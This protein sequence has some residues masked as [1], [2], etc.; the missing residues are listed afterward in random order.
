MRFLLCHNYYQQRGGEDQVFED[1]AWLLEHHGH[2]VIRYAVHNDSIEGMGRSQ[3]V[4]ATFWNKQAA[5]EV[6][7]LIRQFR[8]DVMH[9]TNTFPLISPS[10]LHVATAEGVAVVQTLQN[11][12][13]F[14]PSSN[15]LRTGKICELCVNR[16]FAWP[17]VVHGCYRNDRMATAVVA[18]MLMYHQKIKSW[19]T[20]VDRFIVPSQITLQK[21]VEAGFPSD[22]ISIKPNFLHPDPEP[23]NG[24]GGFAVFAGRL[25]PE[26][27]IQTMLDSWKLIPDPIPLV[28]VGDGPMAGVVRD[29]AASDSRISWLG[30][31]PL[32]E[33][34]EI[35]GRSRCLLMP[36]IWY[37]PFGRTVIEA[38]AVGTPVI[39]S[40]L[41]A[42]L[43]LVN[44]GH[45]G[46]FFQPG[47]AAD[48][49]RS[50]LKMFHPDA[51]WDKMRSAARQEYLDKYTAKTNYIE[52]LAIYDSV[53]N[54][55]SVKQHT[56]NPMA[57]KPV[58]LQASQT[59]CE[60]STTTRAF[61]DGRST[62][63]L[64]WPEKFDLLGVHVSA[65][66]YQELTD[67]I[68]DAAR[69]HQ[70]AVVSCHAAH[71]IVTASRSAE[72][73]QQV[74]TFEAVTPDGQPVRW[75]LNRLFGTRLKDRVYGPE[76]MLRVCAAAAQQQVSIYLYGGTP[77]V[78]SKLSSNLLQKFPNL[79]ISGSEAPPFR[80]LTADED[81][82]MIQRITNSRAGIVF[83]GLGCPKQ[84][85]FAYAHRRQISAVQICVGAAFD[86]HAGVKS[87]APQ[88]MQRIGLEW[89]FRLG[90][91]PRRL[92]K[93]Y[94]ITNSLF[95]RDFLLQW[96]FQ[97]T[98]RTAGK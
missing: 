27:G 8:P 20:M 42:M 59:D 63:R 15:L 6:R 68:L 65:T 67:R 60:Q 13:L 16:R 61:G 10:I 32:T 93:R 24:E 41:G 66:H 3:L 26:K 33:V 29:A 88:W 55:R 17:A 79:R 49:S 25:S 53:L 28:I 62:E 4:R 75:A 21:Y 64:A 69:D 52:L 40:R 74:N 48:L 76:L 30:R 1:E 50:V 89:L 58:T 34:C 94:L 43:E 82:Q 86:F 38:F 98:S 77:E 14:C 97:K 70:P 81:Q 71:A 44:E 78:L 87:I 9:C 72:L 45:N 51:T 96:I 12:R 19:S 2:D 18:G 5:A 95:L 84:D 56:R 46:L 35:M 36:S 11:Y 83:I 91:E 80:P 22:R 37:E 85:Q 90:Q 47:D 23:G 57:I 7:D 73:R 31:R 39:A 92:W 54:I